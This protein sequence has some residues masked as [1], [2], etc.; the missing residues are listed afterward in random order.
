MRNNVNNGQSA[1]KLLNSYEH[2]ERSTTSALHVDSSESK[3]EVSIILIDKDIVWSLNENLKRF[4]K[5]YHYIYKT[6]NTITNQYYIGRHSTNNLKDGYKGSGTV[7]KRGFKKYGK[8]AFITEILYFCS[9]FVELVELEKD[10][11][12]LDLIKDINCLNL[13][14]G[15]L[16]CI[17]IGD[18]NPNYGKPLSDKQ[19]KRLSDM[20]KTRMGIKNPFYGRKHSDKT[21]NILSESAKTKTGS[22][23]SFYN[24]K[25]SE[26]TKQKI[27]EKNKINMSNPE[28]KNKIKVTRSIGV[29]YTPAGN[30]ISSRDAAKANK[31]SKSTILLRC[32][33]KSNS[34]TGTV[35]GIPE[36]Y[37][38]K[39]KTWKDFGFYFIKSN[40]K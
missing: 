34:I 14:P 29:Y 6:T 23:N 3:Q 36:E 1:A 16:N 18:N 9:S 8:D 25:H 13:T 4:D 39:V 31:C 32:I 2:G 19:R 22:K 17:L 33:N 15:G 27:S 30:F 24:K 35:G 7:L 28:L 21:R 10:I 11:I 26:E 40:E 12:T 38:S 37:K 20:A 5:R